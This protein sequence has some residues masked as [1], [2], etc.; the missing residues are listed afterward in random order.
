MAKKKETKK[1]ESSVNFVSVYAENSEDLFDMPTGRF[2][3]AMQ[4]CD[5]EPEDELT[6]EQVKECIDRYK[7][8]K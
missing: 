6:V 2:I 5:I 1:A 8:Q 3:L 7:N 4:F